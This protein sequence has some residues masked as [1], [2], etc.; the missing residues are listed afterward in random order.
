LDWISLLTNSQIQLKNKIEELAVDFIGEQ[1]KLTQ[2][3]ENALREYFKK[4]SES[5]NKT[6]L[7]ISKRA[8]KKAK[9]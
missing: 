6:L 3:E 9:V 2:E 8:V 1:E 5:K 7:K 4:R